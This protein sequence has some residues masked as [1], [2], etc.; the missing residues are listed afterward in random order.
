MHKFYSWFRTTKVFGIP[1]DNKKFV[2]ANKKKK[3]QIQ[4]DIHDLFFISLKLELILIPII[5]L[6]E[7][8]I[9]FFCIFYQSAIVYHFKRLMYSGIVIR[10]PSCHSLGNPFASFCFWTLY[11]YNSICFVLFENPFSATYRPVSKPL[12]PFSFSPFGPQILYY[13]FLFKLSILFYIH[14]CFFFFHFF[15]PIIFSRPMSETIFFIFV[16]P[17]MFL[18]FRE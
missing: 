16:I 2:N 15:S 17:K 7:R 18:K 1:Q 8:L 13:F 12:L 4:I 3:I 14:H 9:F 10:T 5:L 11:I 6:W